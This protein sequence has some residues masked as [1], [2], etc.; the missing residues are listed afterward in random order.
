MISF[1]QLSS[2]LLEVFPSFTLNFYMT[3]NFDK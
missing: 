1:M 3:I 2:K